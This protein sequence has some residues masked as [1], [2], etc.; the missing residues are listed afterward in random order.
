MEVIVNGFKERLPQKMT[1][2]ELIKKYHEDDAH[3]I[4]E[5]NGRFIYPRHYATTVISDG[6]LI[7][8]INPNFGG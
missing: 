8:F 2:S 4:V 6:D 7:E 3:L 1:I 5:H